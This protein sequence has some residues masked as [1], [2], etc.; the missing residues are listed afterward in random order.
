MKH[1]NGPPSARSKSKEGTPHPVSKCTST[2][3]GRESSGKPSH[4]GGRIGRIFWKPKKSVLIKLLKKKET[5]SRRHDRDLLC[6]W[7]G[8]SQQEVGLPIVPTF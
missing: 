6:E 2:S 8:L 3:T 7:Q 1:R 5:C 4:C